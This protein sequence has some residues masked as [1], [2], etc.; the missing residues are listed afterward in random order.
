M[1]FSTSPTTAMTPGRA[2]RGGYTLLELLIAM[3]LLII[4]GGGLVTF[5]NQGISIWRISQRRGRDYERARALLDQVASDLRCAMRPPRGTA[6]GSWI[7]FVADN[8]PYGR[9]RLRFVRATSAESSDSILREGG[10][11]LSTRTPAC[12]DGITD[13]LEADQ[14]LLA[15]PGGSLEVYYMQDPRPGSSLVWR[16]VRSP[17][18]GPGSLLI[19]T[20]VEGELPPPPPPP[21]SVPGPGST[22][23][24]IRAEPPEEAAPEPLDA[25]AIMGIEKEEEA[26]LPSWAAEIEALYLSEFAVPVAQGILYFG[27]SFWGPETTTWDDAP[28]RRTERGRGAKRFWDSTE[29]V[30]GGGLPERVEVVVVTGVPED[31]APAR[32]LERLAADG[33]RMVLSEAL[34]LQ[35]DPRDR[36]VLVDGEWIAVEEAQGAVLQ[37]REN[38]R[39]RRGTA[40]VHHDQGAPVRTGRTFRRVVD[41]PEWEPSPLE[42]SGPTRRRPFG[43]GGRR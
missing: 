20:N 28:G 9:Q 21:S 24:A 38:G 32:L 19:D 42:P 35:G 11:Y 26:S 25:A 22:A 30:S 13:A 34:E 27:F 40:V 18:G 8:A 2:R 14:G 10:R 29:S 41:L 17:I 16:G 43:R 4:L 15:A 39:G 3:S 5:L 6:S 37:V 12:V 31:P 7:R 36:L 33:K 1:R 23:E